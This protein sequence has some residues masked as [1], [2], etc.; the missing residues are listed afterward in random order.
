MKDELP[1][2]HLPV[3]PLDTECCICGRM[4]AARE[5]VYIGAD[6]NACSGICLRDLPESVRTPWPWNSASR[7]SAV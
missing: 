7:E 5:R 6:P 3:F 2:H 4:Y 1:Y